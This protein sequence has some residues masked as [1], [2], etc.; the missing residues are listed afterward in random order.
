MID[1]DART[2]TS[3][4]R[5][6][7]LLAL[8]LLALPGSFLLV[9]SDLGLRHYGIPMDEFQYHEA[10]R[11]HVAWLGQLG[12][13]G[14]FS[15]QTLA[16]HFAWA[17]ESVIHP[18]FSRWLSGASWALFHGGFGMDEIVALRLHNA[19]AFALLALGIVLFAL[20]R[21]GPLPAL[22]ALLLTWTDVRLF[23]HA[24][25]GQ[26]DMVLSCT[27]LWAVLLALDGIHGGSRRAL[28]GAALVAGAAL[29]T[30]MT[31]LL[32]VGLL[33]AW[34]LWVHGRRGLRMSALLLLIPPVVFCVLNPQCWHHPVTWTAGWFADMA[35]REQQT[36]IPTIFFGEKFVFRAPWYAATVHGLITT[37]PALLLLAA[38]AGAASLREL[39]RAK[40]RRLSV[41]REPWVLAT[42]A[43][44]LPLVAC[45]LP[46]VPNHDLERLF[47]PLHPLLILA[48]AGGF[49]LA[50]GWLARRTSRR[51]TPTTAPATVPPTAPLAAPPWLPG[52]ILATLLLAP[53][54]VA[55]IRAHPFELT[56]FNAFIGGTRGAQAAGFDVAYLKLEFNQEVLDAVNRLV[57]PGGE[58]FSN[59][60][61]LD[62]RF[63][64][65]A[66]RLRKDI[67]I[68]PRFPV[69]Y[70]LV[71]AR[72]SWMLPVE[73]QLMAQTDRAIW[74]LEHDG[75]VLIALFRLS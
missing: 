10:S 40:G 25:S 24:H 52:A 28:I 39:L 35:A 61:Q 50:A 74:T 59:Y 58:V 17:P 70:V 12:E 8:V 5:A 16:E 37:P 73:E 66:G 4:H 20:R 53:T 9:A 55:A 22:V 2:G 11:R 36:F 29:S 63:Q 71:H 75:V 42:L 1:A 56:Y 67:V 72:R 33:A 13:P 43:G 21:W 69:R 68:S 62:L 54:T 38:L 45:S 49:A 7:L 47:L 23:G 60:L 14:A 19:L 27:W 48:A 32:L 6:P 64:Q 31:G 34:P 46:G 3:A 44:A 65:Q 18:T 15:E 30:K 57:E 51:A 26:T 41:L